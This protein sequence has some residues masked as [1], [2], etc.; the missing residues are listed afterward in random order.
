MKTRVYITVDTE[1]SM[2]GAWRFAD[3]SPLPVEKRIFCQVDGRAYGL[4][5]IVE[6]L[7][8]HGFRATFFVEVFSSHCLERDSVRRVFDYL[9][10]AGQDVQ[11]HTHPTF[12][13]Y[14]LATSNGNRR[15]FDRYMSLPDAMYRY[16]REEQAILLEEAAALFRQFTGCDAA[17]YRAGSFRANIDTLAALPRSI[18]VDSSFNPG[19]PKSFPGD[20]L[21]PNLVQPIEGVVEL[22]ITVGSC[23][24]P[25]FRRYKHLEIS[26][27]SLTEMKTALLGAHSLG[28]R[29]CVMVF[30]S[31]STVKHRDIF[32]SRIKPDR[33]VIARYMELLRFLAENHSRFEVATIGKAAADRDSLLR[34]HASKPAPVPDLGT[35]APA[36]RKC[37]QAV[38]RVY[39]V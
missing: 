21:E 16:A 20:R 26:A 39:W 31:F 4:P 30:H 3:R 15:D 23:G 36:W 19:D 10:E 9:L 2:G 13:N 24:F 29:H 17:A 22:P 35:V 37:V 8:R 12:R 38:N 7:G 27:L 6:G 18:V 28:L 33:L 5:L 25:P 1:S 32:Y 14:A 34:S 11:L